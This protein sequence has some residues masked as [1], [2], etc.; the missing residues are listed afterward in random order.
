LVAALQGATIVR[1]YEG[2]YANVFVY[3]QRCNACGYRTPANS[4]AVK[5]LP[6]GA[7]DIQS[8]TCPACANYQAVKID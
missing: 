1:E 6:Y 8:F 7:F 2:V 4:F 5:M 3:K